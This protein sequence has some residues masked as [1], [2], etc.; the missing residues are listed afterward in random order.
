MTNFS[1]V[2]YINQYEQVHVSTHTY[3]MCNILS[4]IMLEFLIIINIAA[5]DVNHDGHI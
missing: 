2:S 1:H 3:H 4:I 5:F